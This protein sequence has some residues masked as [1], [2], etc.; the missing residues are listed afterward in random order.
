MPRFRLDIEYDGSLFAGWQH[1]AD[2][3]SVQQAIEQAIEKFCGQQVRLR[4][5]GRTDAG[6]HATAQV[7]HVDLARAWPDDKV[8]DAVNAHLQG[9][10]N[11][12]AILKAT[13]VVDGFDARFS[14]IGRH[15]LYRILNRRAPSAL[16]KGKVWWVP[17]QLDA[18]AMHEAAKV[19]LGR[20]DFTTFR[21]T[22]CQA[23][24]PVRTLD[25]LDVSRS[26][27]MIE[28]RASA[29]S[30]LHNQ[31]RSMVG[32]LKRV[33]EGAWTAGDL[34]AALEAHDR[35]ACGQVAPPDGL[36]LIGVDYPG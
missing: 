3:P 9:A 2:Q 10:G 18:A 15:Y 21:S 20:H 36:F 11:R 5:A 24:S 31:V 35:A 14:A 1:Q 29:R 17:K 23:E 32:S 13:T 19:L 12:I 33:G 28:V 4:A 16:E 8:R 25:R 22:Q 27:D 30:F 7:A 26:G 34:K 6:V